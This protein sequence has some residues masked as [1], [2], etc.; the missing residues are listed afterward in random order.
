MPSVLF[1]TTHRI[2]PP[3]ISGWVAR[4]S[5]LVSDRTQDICRLYHLSH[6]NHKL[7]STLLSVGSLRANNLEGVYDTDA[8]KWGLTSWHVS[9]NAGRSTYAADG[10]WA[11]TI[12]SS[13]GIDRKGPPG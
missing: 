4:P 3:G 5:S 8:S 9:I 12:T 1:T 6:C 2:D 7:D 10:G 13:H 11:E